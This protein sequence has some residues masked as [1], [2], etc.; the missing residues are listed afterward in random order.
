M[1]PN[2]TTGH[3]SVIYSTECQINF[4]LRLLRPI[5]RSLSGSSL[6]TINPFSG[7][8]PDTVAVTPAA[9]ERDNTWIQ[10]LAKNLVWASGCSSWYVDVRTG[11]N[12]M[13][14]PD[15][16]WKYWLRSIFI[17][18]RTDFV[19]NSSPVQ[20]QRQQNGRE[21]QGKALGVVAVTSGLGLV[22]A[23]GVL[24]GSSYDIPVGIQDLGLKGNDFLKEGLRGVRLSL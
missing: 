4:T 17:P 19:F 3:L 8:A 22:L 7:K 5:F 12:T 10:A 1:G 9:E 2:T 18:F 14:Y 23:V 11:K 24:A 13:L 6:S 16:Q 21:R 20:V 15:W